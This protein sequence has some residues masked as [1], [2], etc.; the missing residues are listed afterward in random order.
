MS[1]RTW[2]EN[3]LQ[4]RH[5]LLGLVAFFGVMLVANGIFLYYALATF[6]G[7][8]TSDPYRKGLHYNDMLAA[9]A[10]QDARGW[11]GDLTYDRAAGRLTVALRDRAGHALHGLHVEGA[12]GRPAT[13]RQD[14]VAKFDEML[15]GV[16]AAAVQLAPG[17]WVASVA[18]DDP[19]APADA[20]YRLKQ[21]LFVAEQ[22]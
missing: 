12:V 10:R 7:G 1:D 4:G 15:P 19:A 20:P 16:Y 13:D 3:G 21:R 9:A 14:T 6:G 11:R 22:P 2:L 18:A 5:V 17:Q 8:D